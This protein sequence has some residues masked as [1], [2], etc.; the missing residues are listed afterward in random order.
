MLV[1]R[2]YA[3]LFLQR[4]TNLSS[5]D[6]LE[7]RRE[8]NTDCLRVSEILERSRTAFNIRR[9]FMKYD[10]RRVYLFLRT[11]K[12]NEFLV[13]LQRMM[14]VCVFKVGHV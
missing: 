1:V 2:I 6:L 13:D 14:C 12:R 9:G 8:E 3:L 4:K 11:V 7:A 10:T 5:L